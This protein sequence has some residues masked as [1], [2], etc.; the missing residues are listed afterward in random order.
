[1]TGDRFRGFFEK[2][3]GYLRD[4]RFQAEEVDY[5]LAFQGDDSRPVME[6]YRRRD[7]NAS[8]QLAKA[9]RSRNQNM[10][11]WHLV[12]RLLEWCQRRPGQTGDALRALWFGHGTLDFRF[13]IFARQ[14]AEA[15]ITQPGAQLSIAS[16][17]LM[18]IS[19]KQHP[20]IRTQKFSV[21]FTEAG[22]ASFER[23][24]DAA[25]R[26]VHALR[27]LDEVIERAPRYGVRLRHRLE[28]QG[29]VWCIG[30]G[31]KDMLPLVHADAESEGHEFDD[32][33]AARLVVLAAR[34]SDLSETE[35][36]AL[37]L[38]RRGQ[39]QFREDVIALWGKCAVTGC[40]NIQLLRASHLK[41]WKTSSNSERLD[42]FNG[43]LLAPHFDTALDC[44]LIAFADNGSIQLSSKLLSADRKCLGM[45]REMKLRYIHKQHRPYLKFHRENV[46]HK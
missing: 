43:V 7:A 25:T 22:Y 3:D 46:F 41:P 39:G 17:L 27:F 36:E 15:S 30:G 24:Q 4:L 42:P 18:G 29:V 19:A 40:H 20:P 1:M 34:G 45:R 28:A 35:K 10:I 33:E 11:D 31:W 5:K 26:Y 2:A 21:A 44:G 13:R 16:T 37:V 32:S 8:P 23:D 9:L 6:A 12:Q 38:S 14:L